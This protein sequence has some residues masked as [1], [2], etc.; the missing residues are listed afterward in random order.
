LERQRQWNRR[1]VLIGANGQLGRALQREFTTAP[2]Y[3]NQV[4]TPG[5][6]HIRLSLFAQQKRRWRQNVSVPLDITDKDAVQDAIGG[7]KPEVVIN[8]AAWTDTA[9]CE[10]DPD[11]ARLVNGGGARNVA[12]ACRAEGAAMVHISSNEVFD[13]EKGSAYNENDPVNPLNEYGRSKLVGEEAVRETLPE[14]YIVRTSW[15][16]GPGRTSFPEKILERAR[17]DGRLR[18][19]TDEIA[20]PT[21]TQDLAKAIAALIKLPTYGVYHLANEGEASRKQWATE[22]VRLAGLDVPVEPATQASFDMPF[23]KPVRS[24]L[25]NHRAAALGIRLRPW[26]EALADHMEVTGASAA[27]ARTNA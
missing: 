20:S 2:D 1:I 11:R 13:G 9:G 22:I 4:S 26:G 14:H 7:E 24:T 15:L 8:C 21:W 3:H 12:E 18:V 6:K 19:V 10:R 17:A 16:Y 23:R 25:A 27:P 5:G